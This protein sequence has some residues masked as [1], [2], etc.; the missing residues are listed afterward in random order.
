MTRGSRFIGERLAALGA[1]HAGQG[2]EP[3]APRRHV[4]VQRPE[5]L[6]RAGPRRLRDDR[7][8][9]HV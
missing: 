5:K 1:D 3:V 6:K 2:H 9:L 8:V 4:V 7:C